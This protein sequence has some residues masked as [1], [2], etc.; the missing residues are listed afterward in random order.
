MDLKTEIS[1]GDVAVVVG[2]AVTAAA[3]Y[4][5]LQGKIKSVDYKV[6]ELRRGRGLILEHFPPMVK[7]CFG[8]IDGK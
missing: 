1:V 4:F 2:L 8:Y 3:N 5:G 7:R 6:E